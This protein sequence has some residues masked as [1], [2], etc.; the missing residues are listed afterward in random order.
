MANL[1]LDIGNTLHKVALFEKNE[2]LFVNHYEA[3]SIDK[4]DSVFENHTIDRA[5]VSQVG[6]CDEHILKNL[7]DRVKTIHFTP[8]LKLPI[9]M[10]YDSPQRLGNDRLAAAVAAWS[11]FP[12][13]NT[14]TIQTGTCLVFDF[15]S[16]T[17]N[18]CGGAIAPG[19][20]MRF[21][22]LHAFT[23][24]LPL[25]HTEGLDLSQIP[26][27][28]KSTE[29]SILSGVVLGFVDE[30]NS[31]ICRYNTDFEGLKVILT[32]GDMP[33]LKKS[34]KNVNFASSNLVVEGLN[35]ILEINA[36]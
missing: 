31:A 19:L 32:G 33:L 26:W 17:G 8:D 24:R 15:V 1:I 29:N 28:G 35:F 36:E 9:Q 6:K 16:S 23:E 34:I 25:L 11:R 18:Y 27:I 14:L 4:L 22:A 10:N 20:A 5:I 3:L 7:D 13:Q 12:N 2:L 30:I 21:K